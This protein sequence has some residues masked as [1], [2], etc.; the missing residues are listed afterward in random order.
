MIFPFFGLDTFTIL[1]T[2]FWIW[3]LVDC[4]FSKKKGGGIKIGWATYGYY[5]PNAGVYP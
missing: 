1:T 5:R 3:M 4:L 2:I